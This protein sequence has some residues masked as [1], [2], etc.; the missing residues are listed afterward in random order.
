VSD[1]Q[2]VSRELDPLDGILSVLT[3]VGK[4]KR[5]KRAGW[6]RVGIPEPESVADHS[7]RLALLA[8]LV[9]PRLGLAADKMIRLALLHDLG[10]ARVGDLTPADRVAPSDKRAR[11][12]AAIA[13][14][15][16]SLPEGPALSDL[17]REYD[18]AAT[19]EARVVRQL[20][21]LE[22][23]L[24]ALEYEHQHGQDLAEFWQSARAGLSEPLL[25][26]LFD[27]LWAR[28][29]ESSCPQTR[30]TD[31]PAASAGT[32]SPSRRPG[33]RSPRRGR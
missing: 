7:F 20:D 10:E 16:G 8:L 26:E 30:G 27:R 6:V 11:E 1:G 31:R 3:D 14:I 17:W 32:E 22:M 19:P 15:V 33:R 24:Q 12:A 23:A 28:R 9:G 13:E 21:K 2:T 4:L 25:I 29:P 18:A 5:L